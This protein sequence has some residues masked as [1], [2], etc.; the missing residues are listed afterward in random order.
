[1]AKLPSRD[2]ESPLFLIHA[3]K[4]TRPALSMEPAAVFC[5][6]FSGTATSRPHKST[7]VLILKHAV[8]R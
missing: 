8:M 1:M 4:R 7:L 2:P 3:A 5:G 6:T